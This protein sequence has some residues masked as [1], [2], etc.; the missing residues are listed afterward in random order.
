MAKPVRNWLIFI[1]G[2]MQ[3]RSLAVS[4]MCGLA[5]TARDRYPQH[6]LVDY[7]PWKCDWDSTAEW[8]FR[9]SK[10]DSS[11]D[12]GSDPPKIMV[13]A[14]SW[15]AGWG[16]RQLAQHLGDR[17]LWI[18]TA[19]VSDAVRHVG[20]QWSH[21]L[22]LSQVAAYWPYWSIERPDNVLN[23]HW[24]R[25]SREQHVI[26]DLKRGTTLLYGHQWVEKTK[27]GR[28][29]TC[30]NGYGIPYASHTNMDDAQPFHAKVFELADKLFVQP[31]TT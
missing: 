20:W 12:S 7:E 23:F 19:V 6:V 27:D 25:Q 28:Y 21:T 4:G 16:F 13:V 10:F 3:S 8:I 31:D 15:G 14:Y 29:Q 5:H 18:D 9:W 22:G 11:I 1:G 2:Y 26:E 24:F 30:P 17:G